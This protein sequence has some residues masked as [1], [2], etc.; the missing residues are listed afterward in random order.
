ML[1][2][3]LV[4]VGCVVASGVNARDMAAA[5]AHAES[6]LAPNLSSELRGLKI[7]PVWVDSNR[8]WYRLSDAKG[9]ELVLVDAA[10]NTRVVCQSSDARCQ[11]PSPGSQV[12]A[13]EVASPDGR[14]AA[15]VRD[16][17]LYVRSLS[18]GAQ[19]AL[20]TDGIQDYAYAVW[21]EGHVQRIIA[22]RKGLPWPARV[23]WS[24]DSRRLLTYRVDQRNVPPLPYVQMVPPGGYGSR[25]V[26]RQLRVPFPGDESVTTSALIVFDVE[27]GRRVDVRDQPIVSYYDLLH[28]WAG[29]LSWDAASTQVFYFQHSRGYREVSLSVA[30]A[31]T[32]EARNIVREQAEKFIFEKVPVTSPDGADV[33]WLSSRDGWQHLYHYDGKSGALRKQLTSGAWRVDQI[34]RVDRPGKWIYFT[35]GGREAELDPYYLQLYRVRLD[36]SG[37]QRL[38]PEAT[39]HSVTFSPDGRYFIDRHST[40]STQP[41][42]VLRRADGRLVRELEVTDWSPLLARGWRPPER[43]KAKGRDGRTDI[44]GVITRPADFDPGKKYPVLDYIYGGPQMIYAPRSFNGGSLDDALA[45][46]G[47]IVVRMDGMGTPGRSRQFQEVSYGMGFA[48]AGGLADH[49]AALRELATRDSSL[50]LERVGIFGFSGGGY[51][52]ARAM[53]DYPDFFKVGVA[54]AGSH[55]QRL[56]LAEWGEHFVGRPQWDPEAY[57]TQANVSAVAGLKGKLMLAHGDLDDDVHVAN[58]MQ[59]AHALM[60]A[61][62]DFDMLI[63]PDRLHGIAR[64]PYFLRRMWD[65][66]V[67][68]LMGAAA[69]ADYRITTLGE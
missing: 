30:D 20:T 12:G 14:W 39:H 41:V 48:E 25:P 16:H 1:G 59:L 44:Y 18:T 11:L 42:T 50:D 4:M 2:R 27:T 9:S 34:V 17:N 56:Y 24:P 23:L 35:A 43:F 51:A 36:G 6:M 65:Y 47:F 60:A 28:P 53:F 3:W 54:G 38:T 52:T 68:N 63:L 37:L 49:I 10:K 19:R 46:L 45:Q 67:V 33:F 40:V 13:D 58:A 29:F 22:E 5:Y 21:P 57:R 62:K 8:F 64:D 69:P 32:G 61:N 66:F 7:D 26:L 55:D 15:F 31:S